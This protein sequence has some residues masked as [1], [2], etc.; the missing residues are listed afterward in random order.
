[1]SKTPQCGRKSVYFGSALATY[2]KRE[3]GSRGCSPVP[4]PVNP[5]G[6]IGVC[7][8]VS[9]LSVPCRG[10]RKCTTCNSKCPLKK[11][12]KPGLVPH[13]NQHCF[14]MCHFHPPVLMTERIPTRKRRLPQQRGKKKPKVTPPNKPFE[15]ILNPCMNLFPS[16]TPTQNTK[17][18]EKKPHIAK[19]ISKRR[20]R[21]NSQKQ[22]LKNPPNLSPASQTYRTYYRKHFPPTPA[23]ATDILPKLC[24]EQENTAMAKNTAPTKSPNTKCKLTIIQTPTTRRE[25]ARLYSRSSHTPKVTTKR[26]EKRHNVEKTR[27]PKNK[28][29]PPTPPTTYKSCTPVTLTQPEK[30]PVKPYNIAKVLEEETFPHR[31]V[32][33][34]QT[35]NNQN[36]PPIPPT[37]CKSFALTN[38]THPQKNA[39]RTY[40]IENS[41]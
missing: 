18:F 13:T 21:H 22:K 19:V 10:E 29:Q 12:P 2:P 41:F 7:P 5:S 24:N 27:A 17:P 11:P 38:L 39:E 9:V 1:M 15:K 25:L 33:K 40:K 37:I 14:A 20:V 26:R 23:H 35:P 30:N 8:W 3:K 34:T 16:P 36:Q 28:N 6:G 32:K 31:N 4:M